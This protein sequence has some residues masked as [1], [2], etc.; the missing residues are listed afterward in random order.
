[1]E[2]NIFLVQLNVA[3]K[4]AV[5]QPVSKE[6]KAEL[7][8]VLAEYCDVFAE[9]TSLPPK[10]TQYHR[11]H[12]KG[13]EPISVKPYR[14]LA[15]Q[16]D[17]MEELVRE[18]LDSGVIRNSTSPLSA[19]VVLVRKKDG[20]WRMCVEYREL[21][22]NTVQDKFPMPVIEELLDELHGARYFSKID[23]R[24]GYHQIRMNDDDI[25][26]TTFRTNT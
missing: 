8:S 17:A 16:K 13:A 24:A 14:Y 12:L 5:N 11:I 6:K 26:K 21:N 20:S 9:P 15:V 25:I 23:L 19:S 10:R 3:G 18:M 2:I 7:E 22:K 4:E 1:M